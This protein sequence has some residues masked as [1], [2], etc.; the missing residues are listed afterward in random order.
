[1]TERGEERRDGLREGGRERRLQKS[2]LSFLFNQEK[3]AC[4]QYGKE[5]KYWLRIP[6]WLPVPPLASFTNFLTFPRL[7]FL[8]YKTPPCVSQDLEEGCMRS[9][10]GRQRMAPKTCSLR[11]GSH[12]GPSGLRESPSEPALVE[13]SLDTARTSRT[14]IPASSSGA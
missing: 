14:A 1:M 6:G 5:Q 3:H 10:K 8:V 2:N 7:G 11:S 13:A 9:L 4:L 12:Y